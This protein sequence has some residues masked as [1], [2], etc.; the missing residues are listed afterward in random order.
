MSDQPAPPAS[1]PQPSADRPVAAPRPSKPPPPSKPPKA[2]RPRRGGAL[3]ILALLL[4]LVA[5]AGVAFGAWQWWQ[6]RQH[7]NDASASVAQLQKQ[8][9]DLRQSVAAGQQQDEAMAKA[10]QGVQADQRA[11][12]QQVAGL[13]GRVDNLD[14]AVAAIARHQR[15]GREAMLLDQAGMLLRMGGQRYALFHDAGGAIKALALADQT[16]AAVHDPAL[17]GVRRTLDAERKALAA[18]HPATR[19]ADLATLADLR[20]S[21]ATLPLKPLDADAAKSSDEG[22]W[23]RVWHALSTAVVIRRDDGSMQSVADARLTRKLAALDV[24]EAQAARLAWDAPASRAALQRVAK[25]LDSAFDA[26]DAGVR[27]ARAD[28]E[29]LLSAKPVSPPSLGKALRQ[30]EALRGVRDAAA[31]AAAASTPESSVMPAP[32]ASAP[33]PAA[34]ETSA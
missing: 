9:A 3:A 2:D 16:L 33:A 12:Q 26:D 30:L 18:A 7:R 13:S 17:A 23:S 20:A 8:V 32:A 10:R 6:W 31:P 15:D 4:A 27:K 34:A 24:A 19:A 21:I 29:R 28:V 11:V 22:F 5:L 1:A 14:T 25:A